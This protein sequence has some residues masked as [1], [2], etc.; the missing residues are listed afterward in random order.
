[1]YQHCVNNGPWYSTIICPKHCGV[2]FEELYSTERKNRYE[3]MFFLIHMS[4]I[5][6]NVQVQPVVEVDLF[7]NDIFN[8]ENQVTW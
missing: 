5:R 2:K 3:L 7:P 4:R 8:N 6:I 1:M